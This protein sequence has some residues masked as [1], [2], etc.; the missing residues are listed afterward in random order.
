MNTRK[1]AASLTA[2]VCS[3]GMLSYLP[4]FL[5]PVSAVELV[6]N[7]FETNYDGWYANADAVS[8]TA[9]AG[10]GHKDSRG[11]EVS[12]RTCASDGVSSEKGLYLSGGE[13]NTYRIWVYS[14]TAEQFHVTLACADLDT[15]QETETELVT[16]QV[17]A[18]TWTELQASYQAPKNSGEFRLTITTDSTHDFYFDDV[19][20][21]AKKSSNTVSAASAEKGLKDEFANYFR[22]GNILNGG[23]VQNSTITAS[24]LKDY[25]SVECENETKPDATLVQSQCN[26][27]NIGV[28]LKNAASIMDF[29]VN[30]HLAMRGHTLVWHSQTPVWFFKENFDANGNW[31]SSAVMDQRMETYIKNMFE[32]IQTQ[33]PELNLYAYDVANECISDDQNRTANYGGTREPGEN[34]S[35]QSPWVQIYGSNAFVEKAFTYARKY[36]PESCQLYYNDYN[37]YW[38]HKRDAIYSMCKSLYEKGLLDGIGMQ[39]HINADYDGFS[40]VS[41]YTTAMKK[42]LSIGCDVQIT[43]LDITMENGKYTLQQQADKYK[44]IFQAAMDWNKNP[45]SD[46]RVKAV[47]I[48]GPDDAN[49]WIKTE[50]T[51][52]LYDTNHQPK[53]AY[54]TLTSMIPQSE[55]GD[56]SNP[57]TTEQPVEPNEYGWYFQSTFEGDL[58]GWSGRGD[59]EVMT[60]GR[61]NYVGEEALLVQ[62]RTAAWNG[63]ARSLNPKAFV[64]GKTYSFSTNVQYFDGD[65][66]DTFY[67][68]LQYTDANGDTQYDT[69]A[70][71]TA[72]QGEWMQL[73]NKN[74]KIPE[75][76]TNLQLYVETKD[77]TS[78][79]Y[80]DEVIGAVGGTGIL[81]AGEAPTLT[82]GD[83][84]ADGVI[85]VLDLSLAKHGVSSGFSGNAAKL[86]A[87]VD[88]NRIV[89]AADVK[90]LQDYLLGRMSVFSKAEKVI[91]TA[92][93]EALFA[94][95]TPTASYKADGENNPLFTQRFGADPGVMEYNGRVYVYTTNDV[96]EYDSDGKV[97]E[98]TYAQINKIN[99]LSSADLV[100]WTDH[101]AIPVAGTDGIA[102]WAT[103]SWAPCAA[104]KTINGKE[105][106]FLYFCNGGNGVSVLTADSPTG[107]WTDPLGKALIT[108]ATP[109]CS[110]ITWLFDPAVMVD[111]DGTGY[112]CF[113]GGVPDGKDAMPGTSRI[114]KLGDDMISLA[115]TPV[116]IEAPYLFEDSGINKIG[117]TYYYTYCSNW[118]TAGN[119]YGMT[120]GAIEYMT[121]NNPLGPYTYGGE[122]FRNQGTFFGLYGNNHHSLCTLDGQLYLFY[123]NRSV[124]KAMGIEGNYRSPQVDAVTMQ[125]T[126]I[127]AVTGTMTGIAQKKTINPY[128]TVQAETMSNQ[129][130]IQV[131]GLGD[132][133][134]TEIDQGDWIKVSGV[135]F[136]KGAAQITMKVSSK[137]G[138]AVKICT[139][140]PTGKAV[141]YAEIPSGGTMTTVSAMVQGLNGTQDLYFV[142]SGQA[143]MD[144]W[145]AK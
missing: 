63:A 97:T 99:C 35:G 4:S 127:Q 24:F 29:C 102:K 21:T 129:A 81:G 136:S 130:G 145:S 8:M 121:S 117:D 64:A 105:K 40:G 18:G 88:Q 124:E 50:N 104:H 65:A 118:N 31:V 30:N 1:L 143:E 122:L 56:G 55:W 58:D 140:S 116:T 15:S 23:T 45:T 39:S 134:V 20:V 54:T 119:A 131:R 109:N 14:E 52:L 100:N 26:G 112:L 91:D 82:L 84:N 89:D 46:G 68:K 41:A 67:F 126:K 83:V 132:T 69:I 13:T 66:T 77:S 96:I 10:I 17:A 111:D 133:V 7:D 94:G 61:T 95:I 44:A 60:S 123:H 114:V 113:G 135:N 53:L 9:K 22:V 42:F 34:I 25:N 120:S 51:P 138:C 36:A 101:G 139:G 3:M 93:M 16:K 72:I 78:N 76:A 11:M 73:A 37:E 80:L 110:D 71:G 137:N 92:A 70:E 62:N 32:A 49:T 115:G 128:Q 75:G 59:A 38:D 108:R 103:C 142:F 86:A 98:N 19:T 6:H 125:G 74:Y 107:P 28:S 5:A 79:F 90:M 141:G 2:V 12:G 33:Y 47:C 85:N 43:E 106:F 57:G 48:W 144:S 87:D 27:T